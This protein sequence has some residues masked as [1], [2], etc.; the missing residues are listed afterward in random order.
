M[1][2]HIFLLGAPAVGK[3]TIGKEIEKITGYPL[4]DNA[5]TVDIARLLFD[6]GTDEY[7]TYR[8]K[9]RFQ[10]YEKLTKSKLVGLVSTYC[11]SSP[12]NSLYLQNVSSL[13]SKFE[14]QTYFVMLK[15]SQ[16]TLKERVVTNSRHS[17]ITFYDAA[18]LCQWF[19]GNPLYENLPFKD[20]IVFD[21]ELSPPQVVA[22][23]IINGCRISK[24]LSQM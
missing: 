23:K 18:S 22:E 5:K 20:V 8:N 10:F 2:Q 4:F 24:Q 14:W 6:F 1:K 11:Y 12:E 15:A 21:T 16:A 3:K 13:L 9:L 17:K 19:N 7:R